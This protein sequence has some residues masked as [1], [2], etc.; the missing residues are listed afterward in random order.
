M[1]YP[2]CY[3]RSDLTILELRGISDQL[4][5]FSRIL[6]V[7]C[8]FWT[9]TQRVTGTT[10]QTYILTPI[11]AF[12]I[13]KTMTKYLPRLFRSIMATKSSSGSYSLPLKFGDSL[14]SPLKASFEVYMIKMS[15]VL[16]IHISLTGGRAASISTIQQR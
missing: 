3:L 7:C 14:Y 9:R 4:N 16:L 2:R 12:T 15:S 11:H 5:D 10:P 1:L 6:T 8:K 13:A